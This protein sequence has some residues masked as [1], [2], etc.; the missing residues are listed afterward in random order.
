MM[1]GMF[2]LW[3]GLIVLAIWGV[4]RLFPS[5]GPLA[6]PVSELGS[7]EILAQRYARGDLS[8]EQYEMIRDE[9]AGQR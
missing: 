9:I 5:G 8:R 2:S 7:L 1:I 6:V 4:G 3:A